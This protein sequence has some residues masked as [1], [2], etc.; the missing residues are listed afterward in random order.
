MKGHVGGNI[1]GG[2]SCGRCVYA[3]A[4]V[5]CGGIV[6]AWGQLANLG[7]FCIEEA[8]QHVAMQPRHDRLAVLQFLPGYVEAVPQCSACMQRSFVIR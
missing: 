8:P 1:K 4:M 6:Q 2:S 7:T 5:G 3:I